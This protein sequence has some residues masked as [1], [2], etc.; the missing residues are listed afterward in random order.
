MAKEMTDMEVYEEVM[1][2]FGI[3][4]AAFLKRTDWSDFMINSDGRIW[5]DQD[6]MGEVFCHVSEKGLISAAQVLAAHAHK[7]INHEESQSLVV[8]VPIVNLRAVF[9]L[10]PAA[11]KVSAVFRRPSGKLVMPDEMVEWGTMTQTQ[12]DAMRG[13]IDDHKNIIL[14]GGTGSGKTTLM[15]TF[16][17]MINYDERLFLIEDT[18]ELMVSQPNVQKLTINEKY[19][20]SQ[21]IADTLRGRPTRIIIGEC[22][23]GQQ[24]MQML[25]AWNT[26]HPGGLTT[27]H[28]NSCAEA[29]ERLDQL[30]GE[31][32]VSSQSAMIKN[33]VDV[34]LQLK[35]LDGATR[36]VVDMW[37]IRGDRHIE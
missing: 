8:I 33:S 16:L 26:G 24:T 17:T 5:I 10:P 9:W 31:V 21:A 11:E 20:Y 2:S 25:K 13:F 23:E 15:N 28:A 22:R 6:T 36:K 32:S 1:A 29:I 37:D 18:P 30:C 7:K 19:S 27:L 14:S 12:M 35:R 34:I 3:E 4:L